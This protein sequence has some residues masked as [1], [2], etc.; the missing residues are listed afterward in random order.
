MH[1]FKNTKLLFAFGLSIL[2]VALGIHLIQKAQT[3]PKV[4]GYANIIFWSALW[5]A[6]G[7]KLLSDYIKRTKKNV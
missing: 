3:L 6:V 1:I 7:V 4:I 2:F 5:I